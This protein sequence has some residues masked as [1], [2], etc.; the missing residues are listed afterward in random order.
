MADAA[1]PNPIQEH[2]ELVAELLAEGRVVPFLGAGVNL[3]DRPE[4]F[5]WSVEQTRYL[6]NG[7]ELAKHLATQSRYR[8]KDPDLTR[9]SQFLDVSRGTG[10]LY[11]ELGTV[12]R[13]EYPTTR[14][15]HFLTTLRAHSAQAMD[16]TDLFP[17]I[18]TTNYDDLMERALRDAG[19]EYDLVFYKP[20]DP[21]A[22]RKGGFQHQQPGA[23][24]VRI[25]PA[26]ANNSKYRF[27]EDR[28]VVL[29]IHGTVDLRNPKR[30]GFVITEDDYI[31]YIDQEPLEKLLPRSLRLKL[32]ESHFLFLGYSLA[33]WNLRVFLRRLRRNPHD[34]Y[35]SWAV[36]LSPSSEER[37]AWGKKDVEVYDLSLTDYIDLLQSTLDQEWRK[38]GPEGAEDD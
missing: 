31:E 38:L 37:K 5:E 14:V 16:Q 22:G 17:L 25:E 27:L 32:Q 35:N 9:V 26:E 24:P 19:K 20:E 12:F 29:K 4:K 7:G 13:R 1:Q 11:R 6:P 21:E 23:E 33:D 3:C 18:V 28:P 2:C 10:T 30:E 8:R 34:Q 15:H 36:M